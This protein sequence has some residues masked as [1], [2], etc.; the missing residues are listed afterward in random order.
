MN[1][2][3]AGKKQRR[4]KTVGS[5]AVSLLTFLA[6]ILLIG[7]AFWLAYGLF[8]TPPDVAVSSDP[9]QPLKIDDTVQ[10]VLTILI[11]VILLVVMAGFGSMIAT[12]GIKFYSEPTKQVNKQNKKQAKDQKRADKSDQAKS[13]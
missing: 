6:G 7:F 12:R 11:R 13:A 4:I 9:D 5:A 10:S 8:Q 2:M 1:S 3:P